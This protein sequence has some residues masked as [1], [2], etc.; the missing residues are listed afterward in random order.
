LCKACGFIN[1]AVVDTGVSFE[2]ALPHAS[3]PS[4]GRYDLIPLLSPGARSQVEFSPDAC[5]VLADQGLT[6]RNR[7]Y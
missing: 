2:Q 1:E 3:C 4:C 6:V 7:G 5:R